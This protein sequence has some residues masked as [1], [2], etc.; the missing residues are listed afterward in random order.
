MLIA[1]TSS[2]SHADM[3]LQGYGDRPAFCIARSS[4]RVLH[5]RPPAPRR[6]VPVAVRA[7]C[8]E[9]S[10][11]TGTISGP[12]VS[13]DCEEVDVDQ[14]EF[15]GFVAAPYAALV[16]TAFLLMGDR[17]HA[18]DL[19]QATLLKS[20]VA[21]GRGARPEALEPY[22]RTA[23]LRQ[24]VRWR[25]RR[26]WGE[27]PTSALPDTS[28]ASPDVERAAVLRGALMSLPVQQRAV[29]VLRYYEDRTEAE[30]AQLLG[31]SVGTVKSRA[32]RAIAAL[33]ASDLLTEE[34]DHV[35]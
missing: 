29:L 21:V 13:V 8:C 6:S 10:G 19:V 30:T 9:A 22:V 1:W 15:E 23:M 11:R 4:A 5:H 3:V 18:E 27:R 24:A 17:G 35:R 7:C 31:C 2:F 32:S 12:E 16:R 14:T 34:I 26:W 20:Y 25:K 28:A 33:R